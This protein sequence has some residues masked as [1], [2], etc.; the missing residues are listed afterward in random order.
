MVKHTPRERGDACSN[1]V[2]PI[3]AGS[4]TGELLARTQAMRVRFSPGPFFKEIIW[5]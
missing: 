1:H 5:R 3:W 4:S 2:L